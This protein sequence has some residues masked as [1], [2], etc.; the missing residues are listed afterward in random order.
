MSGIVSTLQHLR[1]KNRG[2]GTNCQA[3]KFLNQDFEALRSHCLESGSLFQD[4]TF[5]ALPSSLGFKE[6]GRGSPKIRGVTWTRPTVSQFGVNRRASRGS[7][8]L[9]EVSPDTV[10]T[11]H[12]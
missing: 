1:D 10:T 9:Y 5:P 4:D 12:H 7:A 2:V 6:L 3:I 11:C 8:N